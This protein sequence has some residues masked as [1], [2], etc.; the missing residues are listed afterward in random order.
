MGGQSFR[1]FK[2]SWKSRLYV[3]S[4]KFSMFAHLNKTN[5][6]KP[7]DNKNTAQ[8]KQFL[9]QSTS[10][11]HLSRPGKLPSA[12][13]KIVPPGGAFRTRGFLT[14]LKALRIK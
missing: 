14:Q 2:R 9:T 12:P 7:N 1:F 4:S 6:Q 10:V 11:R 13:C 3:N 5:K 8:A